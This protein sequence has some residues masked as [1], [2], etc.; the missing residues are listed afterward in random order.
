[1]DN[2]AETVHGLVARN[3]GH[4]AVAAVTADPPV[5]LTCNRRTRGA[6]ASP[7]PSSD[8]ALPLD[9]FLFRQFRQ[10][11]ER[12]SILYGDVRENLPVECD[13]LPL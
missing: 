4:T 7:G 13:P 5:L 9:R 2:G 1:M 11:G 3:D 6:K 8:H 12:R 10:R